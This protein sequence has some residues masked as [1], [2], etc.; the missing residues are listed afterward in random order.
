MEELF[1]KAID[2]LRLG[3]PV[4][5]VLF[6][7]STIAL[8]I[9]LIKFLQ[10]AVL[11][12]RDQKFVPLVLNHYRSGRMQDAL[13]LLSRRRSPVARVLEVAIE[14]RQRRD[15][16]EH[17]IREEV[18][19][20]AT[21]HLEQLRSYLRGL[22]VIAALSPLLGL[23]GTVLG[24]IDAFQQL[25]QAGNRINASILSGG[26]WE[27]LLTTAAGLAI[28]IPVLAVLNWLERIVQKTAHTMESAATQVFTVAIQQQPWTHGIPNLHANTRQGVE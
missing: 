2:A 16:N 23:L 27:A 20:V 25:E 10:F 1:T 4:L 15:L 12:V 13:H 9:I 21:E 19:R 26:I 7:L 6:V 3:G 11:R 17:L 8:A 18:D 24:M 5:A 28:A 14:G 22:E